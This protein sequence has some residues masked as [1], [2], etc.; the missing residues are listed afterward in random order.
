MLSI[1]VQDPIEVEGEPSENFL[2][3]TSEINQTEV[4]HGDEVLL[5]DEGVENVDNLDENETI[6]R[7][8]HCN[9]RETSETGVN[10]TIEEKYCK[11]I[12]WQAG[13]ISSNFPHN[14]VDDPHGRALHLVVNYKTIHH[15]TCME[16]NYIIKDPF[17]PDLNKC[18]SDLIYNKSFKDLAERCSKPI[19]DMLHYNAKYLTHHQLSEKCTLMERKH[20]DLKLEGL[21]NQRK[22]DRLS[23][24]ISFHQR[25][26]SLIASNDVPNLKS[27]INVALK[28]QRS[29]HYIVSKVIDAID[30]VYKARPTEKQK[31]L[32]FLVLKIG[33]PSLLDICHKANLLPSVSTAYRIA[34]KIKKFSSPITWSVKECFQENIDDSIVNSFAISVKSDETFVTARPRYDERSNQI[35]GICYQHGAKNEHLLRFESFQEAQNIQE[36]V[37]NGTIH[38]PKDC[39]VVGLNHLDEKAAVKALLCW[40]TCCKDDYDGTRKIFQA[41]SD[42][43]YQRCGKNVMNICT[44]GDGVRRQVVRDMMCYPVDETTPVGEIISKLAFVDR[45]CGKRQET[46]SFDPKHLVKRLWH[47]F[48]NQSI[49]LSGITILREDL[50]QLLLL[51]NDIQPLPLER[52]IHPTDKQNVASATKF[53]LLFMEVVN[54]P[55]T[56]SSWPFRLQTIKAELRLLST[57]MKGML[58]FFVYTDASLVDQLESISEAAHTLLGLY[59]MSDLPVIANQ[60]YYDLQSTFVDALFCGVKASIYFPDK[61]LYLVQNGTDPLERT[62]ARGRMVL[63]NQTDDALSLTNALSTIEEVDSVLTEKHPEWQH[64]TRAGKRVALDYSNPAA[65]KADKLMAFQTDIASVWNVGKLNAFSNLLK[66]KNYT[67]AEVVNQNPVTLKKPCGKVVGIKQPINQVESDQSEVKSDKNINILLIDN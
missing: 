42:E 55:S 23:K 37:N 34:Q 15:R 36:A 2:I 7:V 25:L 54:D 48:V 57:V 16:S 64:K 39:L 21:N 11:G 27:L 63:N 65:W 66:E 24:C 45:E 38:I 62:F 51:H 41:I 17:T 6:S 58:S 47:A 30:G 33:G 49:S 5:E 28:N 67:I 26:V 9:T 46:V 35:Q 50:K 44:D 60:L 14:L 3:E 43:V 59:Q 1:Q 52:L 20:N 53:C 22:I 10:V 19:E 31:D 12:P 13:N 56:S 40:P 32:A 4:I 61:P 18:C 8:V 29:I